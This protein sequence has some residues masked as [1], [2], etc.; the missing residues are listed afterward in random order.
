MRSLGNLLLYLAV[1]FSGSGFGDESKRLSVKLKDSE[2]LVEE[3]TIRWLDN[4]R[5]FFRGYDQNRIREAGQPIH[6]NQFSFHIWNVRSSRLTHVDRK[7]SSLLC[8]AEGKVAFYAPNPEKPSD[9]WVLFVGKYGS[10]KNTRVTRQEVNSRQAWLNPLSCEIHKTEPPWVRLAPT[11]DDVKF[12]AATKPMKEEHGFIHVAP[13]GTN[14]GVKQ[15]AYEVILYRAADGKKITLFQH[16]DDNA[17]GVALR[18]TYVPFID[19]Y[20]LAGTTKLVGEGIAPAWLI[21]PSGNVDAIA[22]TRVP[23]PGADSYLP[24]KIGLLYPYVRTSNRLD[25]TVN[26]LWLIR[27]RQIQ[28]IVVGMV[29]GGTVSPDGCRVAFSHA[30][31]HQAHYGGLEN[32]NKGEAGYTTLKMVDLC[33]DVEAK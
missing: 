7:M 16:S 3:S 13:G 1:A 22:P 27:G 32:L 9:D 29:R 17:R 23:T 30:I 14:S 15:G 25:T 8:V 6:T 24:T 31:H 18:L 20:L 11:Y 2:A 10:E 28:R 21:S 4:T 12:L 33:A 26:G 5:V 19:K